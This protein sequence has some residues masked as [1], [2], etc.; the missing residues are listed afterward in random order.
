MKVYSKNIDLLIKKYLKSYGKLQ[1]I[2]KY[3]L[4]ES[5]LGIDKNDV[6]NFEFKENKIFEIVND[7]NTYMIEKYKNIYSVYPEIL[8]IFLDI[9]FDLDNRLGVWD[10]NKLI[11]FVPIKNIESYIKS[12]SDIYDWLRRGLSYYVLKK[13]NSN[14]KIF[15][16]SY[17]QN[18]YDYSYIFEVFLN[19][20]DELE[21]YTKFSD[22]WALNGVLFFRYIKDNILYI[23]KEIEKSSLIDN[24][25][26][27]FNLIK[28]YQKNI[29]YDLN[30]VTVGMCFHSQWYNNINISINEEITDN[31][32]ENLVYFLENIYVDF[33]LIA[34]D[35]IISNEKIIDNGV[36]IIFEK[37][38]LNDENKVKFEVKNT[39]EKVVE[40]YI[41]YSS[42]DFLNK[43]I[44][45]EENRQYL[46]NSM[47]KKILIEEENDEKFS[48][49]VC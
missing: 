30:L 39:S 16:F 13:I 29:V 34:K 37:L 36:N 28:E 1:L 49:S 22:W 38:Y 11:L 24:Q 32:Y 31:I 44:K 3:L 27:F 19:I 23:S 20:P 15:K 33:D 42:L 8:W 48:F 6:D 21:N 25:K 7:I 43:V 45:D 4:I 41:S 5:V 40:F 2:P 14:K 18:N 35:I 9:E 46:L 12:K 26:L 47:D 10:N 17:N